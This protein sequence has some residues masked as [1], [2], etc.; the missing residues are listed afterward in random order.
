MGILKVIFI[1]LLVWYGIKLIFKYLLP[2]VLLRFL[3]KHGFGA[4]PDM[5]AG[6]EGEMKIKVKHFAE[7]RKDDGEFGEYV[8]FEEVKPEQNEKDEK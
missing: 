3:R 4:E 1:L 6:K 5:P 2:K 8:D 7:R